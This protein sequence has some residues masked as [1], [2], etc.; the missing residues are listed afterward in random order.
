MWNAD[1]LV[2]FKDMR[3]SPCPVTIVGDVYEKAGLR[4]SYFNTENY[5]GVVEEASVISDSG[6]F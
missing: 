4:W 5:Q 2:P 6:H 3:E 1:I